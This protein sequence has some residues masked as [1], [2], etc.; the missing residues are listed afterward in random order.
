M[1]N[2]GK[3]GWETEVENRGGN[4]KGIT[5]VENKAV[6]IISRVQSGVQS[7]HKFPT[8]KTDLWKQAPMRE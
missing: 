5:G 4:L 8:R 2:G 3:P 6:E 1:V 7:W